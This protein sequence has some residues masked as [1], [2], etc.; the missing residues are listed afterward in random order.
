MVRLIFTKCLPDIVEAYIGALFIDSDFNYSLVQQF[1]NAHILP[2]FHDMTIHDSFAN[3]HP[4]TLLHHTLSKVYECQ[5][6]QL[7]CERVDSSVIG[8]KPK[9]MA[10]VMVHREL[11]VK[12]VGESGRYAK[13]R[14]SKMAN[15]ELM[16]LTVK[17]F[18]VKFGCDCKASEGVEEDA[19]MTEE[20]LGSVKVNGGAHEV[21]NIGVDEEG[22]CVEVGLIE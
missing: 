19:V 21:S 9:V 12:L 17:E 3:N 8:G 16:G 20:P 22:I 10:G 1:F 13:A 7:L 4:T 11:L 2:F 18:K 5:A 15:E 14:V 6:Y